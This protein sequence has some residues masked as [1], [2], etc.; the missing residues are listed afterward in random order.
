M[1]PLVD[2]GVPTHGSPRFLSEAL[3]SVTHQTFAR[4]RLRVSDNG[5]GNAEDIVRPYLADPR[6]SYSRNPENIGLTGNLSKLVRESEAPFVA[7]LHDDDRWESE[8]LERRVTFLERHPDCGFVFSP[9]VDIDERGDEIK[10]IPAFDVER[11]L[12]PREYVP[13]LLRD[14]RARPSPP[15][16]VARNSAYRA[17]GPDFDPRFTVTDLEMW[18]RLALRFPV[19]YLPVWDAGYRFHGAQ[20]SSWISWGDSWLAFQ[21][22]VE[23]LVEAHLPEA[24]YTPRERRARRASAHLSIALDRAAAGEQRQALRALR[25]AVRTYPPAALDPRLA[26]GLLATVAGKRA[27][28]VILRIRY[29]TNRRGIRSP[30]RVPH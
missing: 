12:T 13:R 16:V 5:G 14:A 10:R 22:H 30:F 24:Q 27:R 11:V 2:I 8:F 15:T 17:V 9:V 25:N 21:E 26:A 23:A 18:L 3:D 1:Q 28:R 4:W 19:G 29:T 20:T 7:L 6:I